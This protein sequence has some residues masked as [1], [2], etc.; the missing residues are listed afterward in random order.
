MN[1]Q[2]EP[3]ASEIY[4][5]LKESITFQKKVIKWMAI[6]IAVLVVA[7][8]VTNL[9]HIYQ[10]SQFDAVVIDTGEGNGNANY[11]GGENTGGIYNGESGG[12]QAQERQVEGGAG[13]DS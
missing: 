2:N 3:L 11:V 7:L 4:K 10:W 12:A 1:E 9:Y 13:Q 5:D 8:S 6:I